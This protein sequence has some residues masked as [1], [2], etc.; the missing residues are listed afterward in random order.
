[1]GYG[2]WPLCVLMLCIGDNAGVALR[3]IALGL[4]RVRRCSALGV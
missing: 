2:G 1:M 4:V 3:N